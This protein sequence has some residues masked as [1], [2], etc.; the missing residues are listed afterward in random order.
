MIKRKILFSLL[1][2][3]LLVGIVTSATLGINKTITV[4]ENTSITFE[5]LNDAPILKGDIICDERTCTQYMWK[6]DYNLGYETVDRYKCDE[7]ENQT[8][9]YDDFNQTEEGC[10]S[11]KLLK[12]DKIIEELT[13]RQAKKLEEIAKVITKRNEERIKAET[14]KIEIN[15]SG[16]IILTI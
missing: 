8:V 4:T 2:L 10:I 7:W 5:E 6:G 11:E 15:D 14:D 13:K 3:L 9:I 12:S 16:E 1:G